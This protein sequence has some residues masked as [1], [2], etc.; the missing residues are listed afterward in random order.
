M[1]NF[2]LSGFPIYEQGDETFYNIDQ[3]F[4]GLLISEK[5]VDLYIRIIHKCGLEF[6]KKIPYKKLIKSYAIYQILSSIKSSS[7]QS[8]F[9]T[10][11]FGVYWGL[12][13]MLITTI[14]ENPIRHYIFDSFEGLSKPTK[15]DI[16][17]STNPAS[18]GEMSPNL[19]HIQ[20]LS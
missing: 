20:N 11:E 17:G 2:K 6:P 19:K 1:G 12:T 5:F 14:L 7:I 15:E 4:G 10:A 9:C 18:G 8:S 3:S 13:S 16:E